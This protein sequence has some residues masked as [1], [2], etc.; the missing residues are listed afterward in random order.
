MMIAKPSFTH[1]TT[2]LDKKKVFSMRKIQVDL[3]SYS[4]P[5][6]FSNTFSG[7]NPPY[8]PIMIIGFFFHSESFN[9]VAKQIEIGYRNDMPETLF[10]RFLPSL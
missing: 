6:P 8:L 1:C 7:Y 4:L 3:D 9:N 2:D 10:G 5:V